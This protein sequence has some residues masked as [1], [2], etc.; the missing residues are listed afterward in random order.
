MRSLIHTRSSSVYVAALVTLVLAIASMAQVD[1]KRPPKPP[2]TPSPAPTAPPSGGGSATVAIAPTG[3]LEPS[4][5]YLNVDVTVTCPIGWTVQM[6]NLYVRQADPG[7][8][9]SFSVACTGTPQVGRARVV[10]G[11]RFTLGN[12]TATA[13]V[14]ISRNGQQ[15]QTSSQRTIRIEPGV[16]ARIADQ[17]QLTGTS[18]GGVRI[19]VAVACPIG[20]TPAQSSISVSQNGTAL[21]SAGFAP[22][23]DRF[24]LLIVKR[25]SNPSRRRT[26]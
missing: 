16:T 15:V 13:Y 22:I 21:G 9:G 14:T 18:G 2:P 25:S 10:N 17:G 7:G 4:G 11:N 19:A 12:A 26:K 6:S 8:A 5:E 3:I 1:A 23:C 24:S 20:A